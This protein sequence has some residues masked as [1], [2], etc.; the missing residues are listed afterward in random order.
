MCLFQSATIISKRVR[1]ST[2]FKMLKFTSI[3]SLIAS[4]SAGTATYGTIQNYNTGGMNQFD[5]G[6]MLDS[7]NA[8]RAK[9][10]ASALALDS[11]LCNAAVAH[12]QAMLTTGIFDHVKA[13]DGTPSTRVTAAGFVW[14]MVEENIYMDSYGAG[15]ASVNTAYTNS[16]EHFQNII[17]QGVSRVGFAVCGNAGGTQYWVSDFGQEMTSSGG[18]YLVDAS[19][20]AAP[21]TTPQAPYYGAG[22]GAPATTT[23]TAATTASTSPA[24]SPAAAAVKKAPCKRKSKKRRSIT[25]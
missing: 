14:S 25:N 20:A 18:Q 15:V 5:M 12:C 9:N 16:P 23:T 10:G 13:G 24:S 1:L 8:I 11:R 22:Q 7:T 21:T 2:H 6:G 17:N 19:S 4:V 3:L